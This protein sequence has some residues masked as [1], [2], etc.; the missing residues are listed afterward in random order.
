MAR[1]QAMS[2]NRVLTWLAVGSSGS[3]PP[4]RKPNTFTVDDAIS[5]LQTA[6]GD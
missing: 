2:L 1:E 6:S 5:K 3:L 4:I